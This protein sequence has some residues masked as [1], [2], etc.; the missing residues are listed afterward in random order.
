MMFLMT[1]ISICD[2]PRDPATGVTVE[3]DLEATARAAEDDATPDE[4]RD[5]ATGVTVEDDLAATARAAE[6]D[7]TLDERQGR[8]RRPAKPTP[9]LAE[10]F[11]F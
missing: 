3:D 8:S 11:Y 10:Y 4:P 6:D 7:A 2:G 1:Y 5:P 9:Q